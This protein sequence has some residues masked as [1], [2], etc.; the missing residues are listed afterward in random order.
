MDVIGLGAGLT[1]S[2]IKAATAEMHRSIESICLL[3]EQ[4]TCAYLTGDTPTLADL[5]IAGLS[6]VLKIPAGNYLNIPENLKGKGIPGFAD[7]PDYDIF[8]TWRDQLYTD[9]APYRNYSYR[10]LTIGF[11][12]DQLFF[13]QNYWI[14]DPGYYR[15]PDVYGPYRWVRYYDDAVLV[16]AYSGEVVDVIYNFF[17]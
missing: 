16:D 15:L 17:W 1:P 5:T 2:A 11:F 10:R 3:L 9:Y 14:N 13:G 7:N 6:L 8:F 4:N 12:L